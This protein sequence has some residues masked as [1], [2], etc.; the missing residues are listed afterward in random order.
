MYGSKVH[1]AVL[2]AK[3]KESGISI[4]YVNPFYDEG[5]II[6][7]TRCDVYPND[8]PETLAKRVHNLEYTHFA[9]VIE[10]LLLG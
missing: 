5:Q 3:E 4:H 8:T 6:F 7:Q 1:Q 9:P 2:Q 10:E